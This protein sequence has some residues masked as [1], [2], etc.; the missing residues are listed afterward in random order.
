M[1]RNSF[2]KGPEGWHSYDY[3]ADVVAGIHGFY[4]LTTWEKEGGVD[5]TG[6]IWADQTRW[7]TDTPEAPVSILPLILCLNWVNLEPL[8]LREAELSVYLRG[9]DLATDGAAC[10][11]WVNSGLN[12][13]HLTSQPL[14]VSDGCWADDP[15]RLRLVNDESKWHNSWSGIPPRQKPLDTALA[16]AS[17]YGFAFVGL[18]QEV[19][20]R[21]SMAK[22]EV[23]R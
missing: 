13:W 6:Y 16:T 5:N 1:I 18:R 21:L 15:N 14:H 3:H 11:F 23:V 19:T 2:E 20:G 7:S 22:F 4:V 12:R 17:S 8:D 10:Y 9:D